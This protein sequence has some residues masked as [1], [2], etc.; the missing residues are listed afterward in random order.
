MTSETSPAQ[1]AGRRG[2]V[3]YSR[4]VIREILMRVTNGETVRAI[5]QDNPRMPK[6]GTVGKWMNARPWF[7]RQMETARRLAGRYGRSA[8]QS[9]FCEATAQEIYL[10]LADGE[11]MRSICRDPEMPAETTVARWRRL[12]PDFDEALRTAREIQAE[13][14]ADKSIE[15]A[16]AATPE[17]ATVTRVQLAHIRW[18]AAVHGP[19]T[20]S[21]MKPREAPK[22]QRL[23]QICMRRFNIEKRE[24]GMLRMVSYIAD[25]GTKGVEVD[26]VGEWYAPMKTTQLGPLTVRADEAP[27]GEEWL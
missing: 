3:R 20:F 25:P 22:E 4:P 7:M 26:H 5:C 24:D 12:E 10:R 16:E 18:L 1:P 21:K 13:R 6:A 19:R 23:L 2:Y 17:T 27:D 14:L 9:R 15:I 8:N 11:T